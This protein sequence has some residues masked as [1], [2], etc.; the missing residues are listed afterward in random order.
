MFHLLYICSVP[1]IVQY[2]Q[3]WI[4]TEFKVTGTCPWDIHHNAQEENPHCPQWF[5]FGGIPV[6]LIASLYVARSYACGITGHTNDSVTQKL[7]LIDIPMSHWGL[8]CAVVGG[9]LLN[10]STMS[11]VTNGSCC[12]S[13]SFDIGFVAVRASDC[14]ALGGDPHC[15]CS[16]PLY[17]R[18]RRKSWC[19]QPFFQTPSSHLA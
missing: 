6:N 10:S 18:M 11:H 15:S 7:P 13:S 19:F 2:S 17:F 9:S 3:I 8:M 5:S 16:A 14:S 4:Y 12:L 1:F